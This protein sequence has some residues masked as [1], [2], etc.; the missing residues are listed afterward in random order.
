MYIDKGKEYLDTIVD[1]IEQELQDNNKSIPVFAQHYLR[2]S[3]VGK[4]PYVSVVLDRLERNLTSIGEALRII[5][6]YFAITL[7]EKYQEEKLFT[8]LPIIE[9]A[10]EKVRDNLPYT[11]EDAKIIGE[12]IAYEEVGNYV[13]QATQITFLVEASI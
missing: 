7:V 10:L 4:V 8:D 11:T 5:N 9:S 1:V 13:L 6:I 3:D 2:A 12:D